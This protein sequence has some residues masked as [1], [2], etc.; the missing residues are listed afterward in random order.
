MPPLGYFAY[1]GCV[2]AGEK[3]CS[4]HLHVS[5][6]LVELQF[7]DD[8]LKVPTLTDSDHEYKKHKTDRVPQQSGLVLYDSMNLRLSSL[9]CH[10][11]TRFTFL[12]FYA[13]PSAWNALTDTFCLSNAM[14]S[15]AV[16]IND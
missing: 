7:D 15:R 10:T 13:R 14:N 1:Y 9:A 5:K 11:R 2:L 12:L 3:H 8:V 6:V 16:D 4:G